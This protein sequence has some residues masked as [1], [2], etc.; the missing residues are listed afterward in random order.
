MCI[1]KREGEGAVLN[2][3]GE[4]DRSYIPTLRVVEEEEPEEEKE[5]RLEN[6][7]LLNREL[8]EQ[9]LSWEKTKVGEL[10]RKAFMGT[11]TSPRKRGQGAHAEGEGAPGSKKRRKVLKYQ[12]VGEQWGEAEIHQGAETLSAREPAGPDPTIL[13]E[14]R[15]SQSS[16]MEYM[17]PAPHSKGGGPTLWKPGAQVKD[18]QTLGN[19]AA[20]PVREEGYS[21]PN[22]GGEGV[23]FEEKQSNLQY[24]GGDDLDENM[25]KNNTDDRGMDECAE[26]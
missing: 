10:G 24:G 8:R 22:L 5:A 18:R 23:T 25:R 19:Q 15:W 13:R 21:P 3:R 9:D 6:R 1:R 14:Q 12:K 7:E 26:E 16:I 4:F 20:S 2:S 11:S 17:E